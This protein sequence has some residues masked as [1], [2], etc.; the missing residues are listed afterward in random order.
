[1][2]VP[3]NQVVS[4]GCCRTQFCHDGVT[5]MDCTNPPQEDGGVFVD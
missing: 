4:C 5:V 2:D 1:V 3:V